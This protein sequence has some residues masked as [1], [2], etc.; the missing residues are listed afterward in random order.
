LQKVI[1]TGKRHD[2]VEYR[3]K[4][5]NGE[6]YWHSSSTVPIKNHDGVVTGIEGIAHDVTYNKIAENALKDNESRLRNLNATKDKFFSIIAHDLKNPFNSILGF[7]DLLKD[8][9]R[10]LDID[11]IIQYANIIYSSAQHTYELLENLLEWSRMQQG[12]IPFEPHPVILSQIADNET[13]HLN[14]NASQKNIGLINN[15][16]Q[17]LIITADEYMLSAILRNLTSNA[18]KFTPKNGKIV[19]SAQEREA[20]TQISVSD[21]GV[22][23]SPDTIDKLFKIETSFTT[24]GTANEKGTGLGLLLCK[25]F[26]EKHGG[27]I[28]VESVVSDPT[29]GITGGSTFYFNIPQKH[30]ESI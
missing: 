10:N 28:W 15:I 7:S 21:T 14:F 9:A 8:E 22:G 2:G 23:M 30:S 18:I 4:H 12:T 27:R 5:L 26:V 13:E 3:V 17:K 6:W 19:I 29:S 16:D 25:E 1:E 24:R 11:S 20:V